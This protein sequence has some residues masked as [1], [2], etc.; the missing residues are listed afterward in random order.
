MRQTLKK[1]KIPIIIFL[2]LTSVLLIHGIKL[3]RE[4]LSNLLGLGIGAIALGFTVW[5]TMLGVTG[6]EESKVDKIMDA[7]AKLRE[8]SD[9]R[10]VF[11]ERELSQI[12]RELAAIVEQVQF[13]QNDI[14]HKGTLEQLF[15]VKDELASHKATL[16][17]LT[18][19]GEILLAINMLKS[20]VAHIQEQLKKAE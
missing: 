18:K 11:H 10:D 8:E 2:F 14:G 15:G 16:A 20:D 17:V 6:A 7:I 9:R 1:Y 13:H 5:S 19:Q 4:E 3:R 12:Q